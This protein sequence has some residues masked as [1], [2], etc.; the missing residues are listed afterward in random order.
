MK[1][2]HYKGSLELEKGG[3]V[4]A[5]LD[6]CGELAERGHDV[7]LLTCDPADAPA[8]WR[9]GERKRLY[10]GRMWQDKDLRWNWESAWGFS[11]GEARDDLA[12]LEM[13][14]L[15]ASEHFGTTHKIKEVRSD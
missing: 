4:R 14:R 13:I 8:D 2:V 7:P 5:V 10:L 15:V 11:Q 1:I 3:D 6:M 9:T 12:A